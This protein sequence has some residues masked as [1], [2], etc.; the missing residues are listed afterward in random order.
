MQEHRS[1]IIFVNNRRG[2]E[3]LAVRLN[4]LAAEESERANGNGSPAVG[5]A[6]PEGG[7]A[8]LPQ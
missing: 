7:A 5:E 2:A 4:D 3:R 6:A 8:D 1:T